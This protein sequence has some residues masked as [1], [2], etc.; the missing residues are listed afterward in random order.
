MQWSVLFLLTG[1]LFGFEVTGYAGPLPEGR[2]VF[3]SESQDLE[4]EVSIPRGQ[5]GTPVTIPFSAR[6]LSGNGPSPEGL[7]QG[8]PGDG[9]WAV[10]FTDSF[11]NAGIG[12]I[13]FRSGS[14]MLMLKLERVEEPR[15]S[16]F[17]GSMR[18]AKEG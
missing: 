18:L 2:F 7:I 1:L 5:T 6:S 14:V 16:R 17:Y 10:S 15:C 9:Q 12:T 8:V 3:R 13:A 11:G 4:F